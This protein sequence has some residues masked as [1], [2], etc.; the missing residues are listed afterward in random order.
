MEKLKFKRRSENDAMPTLA[1]Q[2]VL[3]VGRSAKERI[4][5]SN[6]ETNIFP[7]GTGIDV[8]GFDV[9]MQESTVTRPGLALQTLILGNVISC[10][11]V[12]A[13]ILAIETQ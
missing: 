3:R 9:Y 13:G 7:G 4:L 11:K 2:D 10:R 5:E 8:H 6:I 1:I 12:K